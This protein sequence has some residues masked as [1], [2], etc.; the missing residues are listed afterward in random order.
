[1]STCER[2]RGATVAGQGDGYTFSSRALT[3]PSLL[4]RYNPDLGRES[5]SPCPVGQYTEFS[6]SATC[7]SC[8]GGKFLNTDKT[9]CVECDA[10]KASDSGATT[11]MACTG[12]KY[13]SAGASYCVTVAAGNEV[14]CTRTYCAQN[15]ELTLSR[16]S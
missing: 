6:G 16:R 2:S 7:V 11:C 1:M 14:R 9:G 10:G 12:G 5:C 3:P 4:S 8:L 15:K 13:A